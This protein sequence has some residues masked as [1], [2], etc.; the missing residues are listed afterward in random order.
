MDSSGVLAAICRFAAVLAV[1]GLFAMHG[2]TTGHHADL[3]AS[4]GRAMIMSDTVMSDTGMSDTVMS[5]TVTNDTATSDTSGAPTLPGT[6]LQLC[7]AV[8]LAAMTI[9]LGLLAGLGRRQWPWATAWA[10]RESRW[11]LH[12]PVPRGP[13]HLAL[14]VLRT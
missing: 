14:G 13:C 6:L 2:L 10:G 3:S 12:V 9:L 11:A 7:L 4:D 1:A 5:M 8:L